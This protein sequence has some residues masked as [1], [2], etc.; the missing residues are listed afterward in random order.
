M[1]INC[2]KCGTPN[3]NNELYCKGCGTPLGNTQYRLV[4][5]PRRKRRILRIFLY[6][7]LFAGLLAVGMYF[8]Y[9]YFVRIHCQKATEIIFEHGKTLDFSDIDPALLPEGLQEEPNV[10]VQLEEAVKEELKSSPVGKYLPVEE[11]N[12]EGLCKEITSG[13]SYEVLDT[14]VSKNRCTVTVKTENTDFSKIPAELYEMIKSDITNPDSEIWQ[15]IL[16]ILSRFFGKDT[17][18]TKDVDWGSL[19]SDYYKECKEKTPKTTCTGTITYGFDGFHITNWRIKDYDRDLI[20]A[21]YGID[22][23]D[24][25]FDLLNTEETQ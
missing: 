24:S 11:I 18:N 21:F 19:L 5:K 6:V 14:E 16:G 7:L 17:E 8:G 12:L 22:I 15:K 25:Y 10:R 9:R 2:P 20:R 1:A 3:E 4:T 23:P 13:A